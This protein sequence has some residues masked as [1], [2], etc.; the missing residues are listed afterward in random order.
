MF[1]ALNEVY[2]IGYHLS[3]FSYHD[4]S[5]R[6]VINVLSEFHIKQD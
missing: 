6:N 1:V 4:L 2:I 3:G 5:L